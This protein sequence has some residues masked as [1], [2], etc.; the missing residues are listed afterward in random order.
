[1]WSRTVPEPEKGDKP[2]EGEESAVD[3][4]GWAPRPI[5]VPGPAFNRLAPEVR[6]DLNRL[7]QN[8]GHPAPDLFVKILKE[9]GTSQEILDGAF[10]FQCATCAETV[11]VPLAKQ[12]RFNSS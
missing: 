10:E 5:T 12:T 11:G 9:R 2:V 3:T 7:H 4:T 1:M 8:L 6:Q